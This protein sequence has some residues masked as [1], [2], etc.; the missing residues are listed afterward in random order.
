MPELFSVAGM[1]GNHAACFITMGFK[2]SPLRCLAAHR[3]QFDILP[4]FHLF[5]GFP[6]EP[7]MDRADEPEKELGHKF[8]QIVLAGG[9]F[10]VIIC[11]C[12]P[13]AKA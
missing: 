9:R 3:E 2:G 5:Y 7:A 12:I 1:V 10:L 8:L 4:G 6:V 13:S 11:C